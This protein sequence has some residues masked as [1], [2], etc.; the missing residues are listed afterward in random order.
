[1]INWPCLRVDI[2]Q[3]FQNFSPKETIYTLLYGIM[4]QNY[5][6]HTV[7]HLELTEPFH[8][9]EWNLIKK[10]TYI[11]TI[12]ATGWDRKHVW[13][14]KWILVSGH[15]LVWLRVLNS[16]WC[17]PPTQSFTRLTIPTLSHPCPRARAH[18]LAVP[19]TSGGSSYLHE[20]IMPSD[21]DTTRSQLNLT[22]ALRNFGL[23]YLPKKA[24]LTEQGAESLWTNSSGTWPCNIAKIF[25]KTSDPTCI[26]SEGWNEI[27]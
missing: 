14:G 20:I 5:A 27:K 24:P 19:V 4:S 1:M 13:N 25:S 11:A 8:M 26:C 21:E 17:T 10:N 15:G 3:H 12:K 9:L 7:G 2:R 18:A 6:D 23:K 16:L 22:F